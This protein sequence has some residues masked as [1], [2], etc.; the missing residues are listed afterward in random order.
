MLISFLAGF[1]IFA[2]LLMGTAILLQQGKGDL[3]LGSL[4]NSA[5]TM[6]GGS[7]GQSFFEKLTWTLAAIFI[8]GSLGLTVLKMRRL[9]T[10]RVVVQKEA[11][12]APLPAK[13][14]DEA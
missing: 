13:S 14:A 4:N 12:I 11:D 2:S 10:S 3:G 1:F 7:G 6:F 8:I 5:Q 9:D